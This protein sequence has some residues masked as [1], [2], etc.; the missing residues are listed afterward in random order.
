MRVDVP[1]ILRDKIIAA[2]AH[3]GLSPE[4][5]ARQALAIGVL[6]QSAEYPS[7]DVIAAAIIDDPDA[8]PILSKEAMESTGVVCTPLF[9]KS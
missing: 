5:F 2:A 9:E 7:D 8:P 4:A 3:K 6:L 1:D